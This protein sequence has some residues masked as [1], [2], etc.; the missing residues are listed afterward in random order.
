VPLGPD[1]DAWLQTIAP[2]GMD[3]SPPGDSG[4]LLDGP[5]V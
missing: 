5:T 4:E 2:T 3:I 1:V